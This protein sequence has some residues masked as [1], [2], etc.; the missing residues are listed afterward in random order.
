MPLG[1][2]Y[3]TVSFDPTQ[4]TANVG[5]IRPTASLGEVIRHR[6]K[7]YQYV[8]FDNG[9]GNIAAVNGNL[10]YWKD[11]VNFVVTS[12]QSDGVA[13]AATELSFCAGVFLNVLT[14]GY[15][16][17]IQT[18]GLHTSLFVSGNGAIGQLLLPST[19]D[20]QATTVAT[21][22]VTAAQAGAEVVGRQ[23]A[24]GAANRA[25]AFL[26]ILF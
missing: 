25:A 8:R 24:V 10:A 26:K 7:T 6:G 1:S 20:G 14:D 19:T 15:Y 5:D 11:L 18:W 13:Q 17:W 23:Y 21:G 4:L 9:V 22:A 3:A 16:G 12:D 2:G